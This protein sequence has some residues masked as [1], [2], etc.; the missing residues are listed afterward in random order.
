[1]YAPEDLI[2]NC[3]TCHFAKVLRKAGLPWWLSG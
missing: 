2:A 1:M 3:G